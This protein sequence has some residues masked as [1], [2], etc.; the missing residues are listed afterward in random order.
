MALT[1]E[2]RGEL[3]YGAVI[4][5]IVARTLVFENGAV[6][7]PFTTAAMIKKT[8][9]TASRELSRRICDILAPYLVESHMGR[10]HWLESDIVRFEDL[11][12]TDLDDISLNARPIVRACID[13]RS[14]VIDENGYMYERVDWTPCTP[15]LDLTYVYSQKLAKSSMSLNDVLTV[16]RFVE[17]YVDKLSLCTLVDHIDTMSEFIETGG[18]GGKTAASFNRAQLRE[19]GRT[20]FERRAFDVDLS[21][22]EEGSAREARL[23]KISLAFGYTL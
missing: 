1:P 15:S 5:A 11:Y 8:L 21:R 19:F 2:Q 14:P 7:A 12:A 4:E 3:L 23:Q 17:R 16:E 18:V 6:T 22:I 10:L 20:L 13:R 9:Q